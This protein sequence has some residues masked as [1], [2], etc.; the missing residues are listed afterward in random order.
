MI[1]L[2]ELYKLQQSWK[3]FGPVILNDI[4]STISRINRNV[5][6]IFK[7]IKGKYERY[8]CIKFQ[9]FIALSQIIRGS[10]SFDG[11]QKYHIKATTILHVRAVL[12]I[13]GRGYSSEKN[14]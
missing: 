4:V 5:D 7:Q 6:E 13:L 3:D 2:A 14:F 8:P 11:F 1:T 12:Q 9:T 10:L